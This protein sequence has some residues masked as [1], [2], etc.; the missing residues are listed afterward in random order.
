MVRL[1]WWLAIGLAG[2]VLAYAGYLGV[3]VVE[4]RGAAPGA[5]AAIVADMDPQIDAIPQDW[6]EALVRV[7]DPTFWTNDGID[8]ASPGAGMTTLSQALGKRIFFSR[9]RPGPGRL[10]KIELMVLTRFALTPTVEK[11]DILRAMLATAYLGESDG[12]AVI[13]FAAGAR[14]WYGKE[15]NEL[16]ARQFLGLVAMLPAPNALDPERH[17]DANAERV[18][19]I[20]RLMLGVCRP[21]GVDDVA[22]EGCKL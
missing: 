2:L 11:R 4:Q 18:G 16:S 3:R 13:G 14:R 21:L 12:K 5:V 6:I 8:L 7:E 15:L 22:L 20:E 19:R 9:F 17:A 1:A 10:G